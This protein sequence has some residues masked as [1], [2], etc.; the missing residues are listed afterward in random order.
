M[1][2]LAEKSQRTKTPLTAEQRK[3]RQLLLNQLIYE[4]DE[5]PIYYAGYKDVL[6]G[7]K[8][9]AS[10]T[11]A[12]YLQSYSVEL[13]QEFLFT[14]PLR[15][16]VRILASEIGVQIDKKNGVHATSLSMRKY[17]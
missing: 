3:Q 1:V 5:K 4:M 6:N 9:P 2:P 10:I 17:V 12:S 14:H 16:R 7:T 8:E 15:Q 11:G 13:I